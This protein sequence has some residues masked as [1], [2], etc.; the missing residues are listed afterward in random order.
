MIFLINLKP[1]NLQCDI[2]ARKD[3]RI[4]IIL[5]FSTKSKKYVQRTTVS[6]DDGKKMN[7]KKIKNTC[8][9]VSVA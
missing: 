5:E 6:P 8:T 3:P 9:I 7:F 4:A 1:S 2:Y